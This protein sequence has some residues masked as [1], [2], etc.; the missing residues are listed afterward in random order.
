MRNIL[1]LPLVLL[2]TGCLKTA[3]QVRREQRLENMSQQLS[4]SQ[5]IVA[6]L[7]VML[8]NLQTQIDQLNGKVEELQHQQANNGDLKL[9]KDQLAQVQAQNEA[10]AEG[11][12]KQAEEMTQQRAFIE[13]VTDKLGKLGAQRGDDSPKKKPKEAVAEALELIKRKKNSQAR[14][15]LER[16]DREDELSAA[17]RNKVWHALG[18][19]E[20]REDKHEKAL[21]YFSK[22]YTKYPKSSLA[23]S[24][25]AHIADSLEKLGKKD[26]A[27]QA[28]EELRSQYPGSPLAKKK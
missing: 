17:D 11:Q 6:D 23:P 28:R 3:D 22:I 4:D 18:I 19:L 26:E 5:N 1:L 24:S 12:K 14:E 20:Q 8:K 16:I 10:L 25:L 9:I 2:V 27:A 13:K 15:A 7:T 21:V